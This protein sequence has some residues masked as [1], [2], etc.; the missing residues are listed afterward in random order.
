MAA[1]SKTK[2]K[3]DLESGCNLESCLLSTLLENLTDGAIA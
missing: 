3:T 1:E 2:K